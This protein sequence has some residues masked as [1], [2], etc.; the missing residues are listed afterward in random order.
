MRYPL[1]IRVHIARFVLSCLFVAC[2]VLPSTATVLIDTCPTDPQ[3]WVCF[4][5]IEMQG[6]STTTKIY[7]YGNRETLVE[8]EQSGKRWRLITTQKGTFVDHLEKS[9]IPSHFPTM[10]LSNAMGP[11][12]MAIPLLYPDGP[13]SVPS[14]PTTRTV[15]IDRNNTATVSTS[16]GADGEIR[17]DISI[18]GDDIPPVKGNYYAGSLPEL[19]RDFDLSG[20]YTRLIPNLPGQTPRTPEPAPKRLEMLRCSGTYKAC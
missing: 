17:F 6:P 13:R 2:M 11:F 7:N 19:P 20:W 1:R 9:D 5:Y 16:R 4:G 15:R 12:F 3:Q 18:Q 14:K 8:K 10:F